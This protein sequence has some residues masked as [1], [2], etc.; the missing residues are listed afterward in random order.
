MMLELMTT[1]NGVGFNFTWNDL[2]DLGPEELRVAVRE[3]H[4]LWNTAFG[5]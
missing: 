2:Q 1:I 4:E 3:L 5:T